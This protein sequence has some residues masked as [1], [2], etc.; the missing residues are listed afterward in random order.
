MNSDRVGG[1]LEGPAGE[2]IGEERGGAS[3]GGKRKR[4]DPEEGLDDG[5]AVADEFEVAGGEGLEIDGGAEFDDAPPRA[6]PPR[7]GAGEEFFEHI[8][9]GDEVF[10]AGAAVAG[11][12]AGGVD[13]NPGVWREGVEQ[14]ANIACANVE[15]ETGLGGVVGEIE[16]EAGGADGGEVNGGD[17]GDVGEGEGVAADAGA[18]VE[19]AGGIHTGELLG[20]VLGDEGVGG[21]FEGFRGGPDE[22]DLGELGGGFGLEGGEGEG[23]VEGFRGKAF[24]EGGDLGDGGVGGGGKIGDGLAE[25]DALGGA[26]EVERGG[27]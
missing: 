10:V 18:E 27:E 17:G 23:G 1:G 12:A 25:E 21:L 16:V 3:V 20:F 15:G 2:G 11:G 13:V 4:A 7:M 19:D 5:A 22:G 26:Q 9:A 24:A 6:A 14:V 8:G